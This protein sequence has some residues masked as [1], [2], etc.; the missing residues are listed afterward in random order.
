MALAREGADD[1]TACASGGATDAT[2]AALQLLQPGAAVRIQR[3]PPFFTPLQVAASVPPEL[4]AYARVCAMSATEAFAV[5][6]AALQGSDP[7]L[8][9]TSDAA[10]ICSV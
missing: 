1:Q 6:E 8:L 10:T 5:R 3:V 4:N 7:C 9:Y 2:L